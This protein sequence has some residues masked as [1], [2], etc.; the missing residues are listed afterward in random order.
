MRW[1]VGTTSFAVLAVS[2]ILGWLESD[3]RSASVGG[4]TVG[5]VRPTSQPDDPPSA[6]R[7]RRTPTSEAAT[8]P[9]APGDD[10]S[11][12]PSG[13]PRSSPANDSVRVPDKGAGTLTVVAGNDYGGSG[14]FD[15]LAYRV[16]IEDGLDVDGQQVANMVHATLTD[17]RG[18]QE[19]AG[20]AF[21][22]VDTEEPDLR[23]ILAT[24]ATTDR[25]CRPLK[26]R[27][28]LSCRVGERVVLNAK[29]WV[30]AVPDYG[31]A[32]PAYRAYLVNHEV[33][34]ALG[35]GHAYCEG[36]NEP[37]PV[38]MQQSKG[39]GACRPNGWP[40]VHAS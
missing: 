38:M 14:D 1:V 9:S 25:L 18:W 37:A 22:R 33:G 40:A 39:V 32:V 3:G 4:S 34:H 36:R 6:P 29:R 23:V 35:R 2:G 19:L 8:T 10:R 17:P 26:T 27:G 16:E 30:S 24:P 15:R 28:E 11:K 21:E 20:V 13:E 31:G 12:L 7:A 5:G